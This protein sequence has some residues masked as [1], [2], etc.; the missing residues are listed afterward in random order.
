MKNHIVNTG[1]TTCQFLETDD[2]ANIQAGGVQIW[3]QAENVTDFVQNL[4]LEQE[5]IPYGYILRI[6]HK[7]ENSKN[8]TAHLY[9]IGEQYLTT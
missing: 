8:M 7:M 9:R 3:G 1:K 6:V 2:Y 5:W 4:R